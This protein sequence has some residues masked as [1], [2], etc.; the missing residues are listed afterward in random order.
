MLLE[1]TIQNNCSKNVSFF[2]LE[3]FYIEGVLVYPSFVVS[4]LV[5][6]HMHLWFT[7]GK[8]IREFP[9]VLGVLKSSEPGHKRRLVFLEKLINC[10]SNQLTFVLTIY[11]RNF[12]CYSPYMLTF[13]TK[14]VLYV[15]LK[16]SMTKRVV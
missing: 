15:I 14:R 12:F 13:K 10:Q 11:L 8:V 3:F 1:R 6:V 9:P 16:L 4:D 2:D 7:C 5:W